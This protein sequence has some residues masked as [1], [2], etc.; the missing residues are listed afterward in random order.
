MATL[1]GFYALISL[2]NM[3]FG[4]RSRKFT[5]KCRF[6]KFLMCGNWKLKLMRIAIRIVIE[7]EAFNKYQNKKL[8]VF[9]IFITENTRSTREPLKFFENELFWSLFLYF[10]KF[11]QNKNFKF[12]VW[13]QSFYRWRN[14]RAISV[15]GKNKNWFDNFMSPTEFLLCSLRDSVVE[16]LYACSNVSHK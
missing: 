1:C 4:F 15:F 10:S 11:C 5:E 8:S 7:S 9:T 13:R 14:D 2:L 3:S 12:D 6:G 16:S